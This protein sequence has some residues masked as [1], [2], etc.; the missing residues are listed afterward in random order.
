MANGQPATASPTT[1][2]WDK[3]V[4]AIIAT[5]CTGMLIAMTW[6]ANSV[7]QMQIGLAEEKEARRALLAAVEGIKQEVSG[8]RQGLASLTSIAYTRDEARRD[9]SSIDDRLRRYDDRIRELERQ[10]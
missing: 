3:V 1:S 8:L 5:G 2:T 10:Q 4:G 9:I 7:Q 6:V